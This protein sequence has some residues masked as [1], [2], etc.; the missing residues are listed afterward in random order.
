VQQL[1]Q[2]SQ[3]PAIALPDL[4][5]QPFSL[6]QHAMLFAQQFICALQH[7]APGLQHSAPGLQHSALAAQQPWFAVHPAVFP[8]LTPAA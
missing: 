2:F 4:A 1:G 3:H 6:S 5:A 7:S 8:W